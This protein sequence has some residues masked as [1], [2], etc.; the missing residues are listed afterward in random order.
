MF[1]HCAIYTGTFVIFAH[2]SV[3]F[4]LLIFVSHLVID[5]LKARYKVIKSIWQDQLLHIGVI[6]IAVMAG[7]A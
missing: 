5:S 2:A 6:V 1:Y 4:A 3:W 7:L